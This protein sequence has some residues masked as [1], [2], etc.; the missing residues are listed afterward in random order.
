[1]DS[2]LLAIASASVLTLSLVLGV[3][4]AGLFISASIDRNTDACTEARNG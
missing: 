2:R 3:V 1:M 4:S